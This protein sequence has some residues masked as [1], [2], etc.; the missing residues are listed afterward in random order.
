M[1]QGD[2]ARKEAA[3]VLRRLL[4]AVDDGQLD[5]PGSQGARLLRRMEG[6]VAAWEAEVEAARRV[7]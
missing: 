1:A 4:D 5:A 3:A 6:A 2:D 7:G